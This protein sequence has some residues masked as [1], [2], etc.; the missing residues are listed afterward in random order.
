VGAEVM[1]T[2]AVQNKAQSVLHS[3][4]V[5]EAAIFCLVFLKGTILKHN[6]ST[7]YS[8]SKK[9]CNPLTKHFLSFHFIK[10]KNVVQSSVKNINFLNL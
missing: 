9:R 2:Q 8:V 3:A 5:H 6:K 4:S 7:L 1:R 10:Y